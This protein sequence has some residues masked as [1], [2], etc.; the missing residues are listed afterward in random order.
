M[1]D[2]TFPQHVNVKSIR[3]SI[4]A[5]A[6]AVIFL[7]C[8]ALVAVSVNVSEKL[9]IDA[10]S[11]DMKIMTA[12]LMNK[13]ST[14]F[15]DGHL[16]ASAISTMSQGVKRDESVTFVAFGEAIQTKDYLLLV[17]NLSAPLVQNKTA[18]L[19]SLL[20]LV[21]FI[22]IFVLVMSL[23]LNLRLL[24]P[25]NELADYVRGVRKN[26]D[27]TIPLNI[28][29]KQEINVLAEEI[30]AMVKTIGEESNKH[31]AHTQQLEKQQ[32][33]MERLAN[34]DLLTGLPN[35]INFLST[36]SKVLT[37]IDRDISNPA[38]LSC[39]L[40]GFKAINDLHGHDVGDKLLIEVSQRLN[41]YMQPSDIVSRVGGDEFLV[42]MVA[43]R[44][45][46]QLFASA[47][48]VASGLSETF[49]IDGWEINIG[50]SIGIACAKNSDY[51]VSKLISNA[52]I[53]MQ[54]SKSMGNNTYSIFERD[55]MSA[56]KRRLDIANAIPNA[57]K[58]REFDL[59]YQAKVNKR[60]KVVGF[61]ALLRWKSKQLGTIAPD[62]FIPIAEQSGRMT[63]LTH[64]VINKVC[65]DF[66]K[67]QY[68]YGENIVVAI[69]LSAYDLTF[70]GLFEVIESTFKKY[71]INPQ[72]IEFE[73]TESAFLDNFEQ[74][75]QFF[76][77]LAKIGSSVALDDFGTGYS[78]LSYLTKIQFNTLKIDKQFIDGIGI[79]QRATLITKTIIEMAKNL[80][81]KVCAEGVE[82]EQQMAFLVDMNCEQLQGYYFSKPQ[83]I[84]L[85]LEISLS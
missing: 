85:L 69:N 62:E 67:F 18:L 8:T 42:L 44:K 38:L 73:V 72:S 47:Q 48:E 60:R 40:N 74:A 12:S 31:Q 39:D 63:L 27:Y 5:Y 53:A 56:N 45:T 64:W 9:H 76:D 16:P 81:L 46:E 49:H 32:Q 37:S 1:R 28:E 29:G 82:T 43:P 80:N 7:T 4:A 36:A 57:L 61:E 84:E 26:K 78:S 68:E 19:N 65:E 35:R 33:A 13:L 58:L 34:Y 15:L 41:R 70:P 23:W 22:I 11:T 71:H 25:L 77:Q 79:S 50:V 24:R 20:P 2:V 66:E 6:S 30:G 3:A 75:N 17:K 10:L 52:N 54:R 51:E 14:Q 59:F 83:P 55:M 21:L